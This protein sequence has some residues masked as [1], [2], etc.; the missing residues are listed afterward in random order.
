MK[1]LNVPDPTNYYLAVSA[2]TVWI[3]DILLSAE[4]A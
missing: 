1:I 4:T 3:A 2:W